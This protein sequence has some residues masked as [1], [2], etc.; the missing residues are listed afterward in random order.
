LTY[1]VGPVSVK[2][3]EQDVACTGVSVAN[4][5]LEQPGVA[6]V[7]YFF[8][9]DGG[10]VHV[11]LTKWQDGTADLCGRER[12]SG[13]A[14]YDRMISAGRLSLRTLDTGNYAIRLWALRYGS[15]GRANLAKVGW[16]ELDDF[17]GA[18]ARSYFTELG[19]VAIGTAQEVYGDSGPK[20]G[21]LTLVSTPDNY[22]LLFAV[23]ALTRMVPLMLNHGIAQPEAL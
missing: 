20:R 11:A 13:P 12:V 16:A 9:Q 15:S 14:I 10:D 23:F 8:T 22:K 17:L 3:Q 2:I 1:E 4:S 7:G 5:A 6:R 18:N 19:A 21:D